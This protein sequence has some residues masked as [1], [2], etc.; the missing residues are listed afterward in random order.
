MRRGG[1]VNQRIALPA[2]QKFFGVF[3]HG[4]VGFIVWR[5]KIDERFAEHAAHAGGFGFFGDGIFEVI[6]VRECRDARTNLF[7][8]REPRAPS[9]EIFGYVFRLGR[10]KYIFAASRRA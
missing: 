1:S 2:L 6:H 9:H 10:E 7:G 4:S 8:G 3:Q 5:W